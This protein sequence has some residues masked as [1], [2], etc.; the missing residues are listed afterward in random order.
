MTDA[1]SRHFVKMEWNRA[2][3]AQ[4]TT[5][6]GFLRLNSPDPLLYTTLTLPSPST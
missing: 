4:F 2:M 5:F 6:L 3:T 1:C